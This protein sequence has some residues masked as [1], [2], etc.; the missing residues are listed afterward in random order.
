MKNPF[1]F[2]HRKTQ[3]G[4]TYLGLFLKEQ[5]GIVLFLSHQGSKIEI[6]AQEKFSYTDGWEKLLEDIDEV[7][8]KLETTTGKSPEQTIFFVY[9]H[10][11]DMQT[12]EIR[13]P[14]LHKIKELVKGLELKPLGFIECHEAVLEHLQKQEEMALTAI[15]MEFDKTSLDVFVYASGNLLFSEVVSRTESVIDDLLPVFEKVREKTVL[16]P[17]IILYN[18][19]DLDLESTN[20]LTH[21]WGRDFF[22][23]LPKVQIVKE[24][25]L[26]QSLIDIFMKQLIEPDMSEHHEHF[27]R[28]A[29][30]EPHRAQEQVMGFVVGA[31]VAPLRS[32]QPHA[33]RASLSLFSST[34]FTQAIK[35][36]QTIYQNSISWMKQLPFPALPIIGAVLIVGSLFAIEFF[37][38]KAKVTVFFPSQELIKTLTITAKPNSST[39]EELPLGVATDTASFTETR[40]TTG[41]KA[42][43]EKAK[44]EVTVLNYDSAEKTFEKGTA[45]QAQGLSFALNNE[46]KVAS[47]SIAPDLSLQ[48]GK[49]KGTVTAAQ[50]GPE[51][52]LAK[53]QRFQVGDFSTTRYLATNDT[54]FSGGTKRDIR[55]VAKDDVVEI[56]DAI[57]KKAKDY[58]SSQIKTKL[59]P[60]QEIVLPLTEYDIGIITYSKE[61]GDEAD[62]VDGKAAVKIGYYTYV[63]AALFQLFEKNLAGEI[64]PGFHLD[65][66][67]ITYAVKDVQSKNSVYVLSIDV[68]ARSVKEVNK[69]ELM[70]KIVGKQSGQTEKVLKNEY[71]ADG[72]EFQVSHPIPFMKGWLPPF[73]KNI[74]LEISYL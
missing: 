32:E 12:K 28:E 72:A 36:I 71:N 10:L 13:K 69:Q 11:I 7:L 15:V 37:F 54:A 39:S 53:G 67:K 33:S 64:K 50:I 24:T 16:P 51:S 52:N 49:T 8:N 31:D 2:F 20:I 30:E 9:S 38:H 74:S 17:R 56:K 35:I 3:V 62:S 68:K 27:E 14:Y 44:G 45:I 42:T 19:I 25:Q 63:K 43:G 23:Q 47:S 6:I 48:P 66:A 65:Q 46:V 1:Q 61:L 21:Q 18:S 34:R 29:E 55:V 40:L 5:E 58:T 57:G 73:E 4:E 26:I 41:K 59:G 60:N 70:S 22:I